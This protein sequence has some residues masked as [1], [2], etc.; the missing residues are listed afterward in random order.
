[1][2]KKTLAFQCIKALS[3]VAVIMLFY[4]AFIGGTEGSLLLPVA[5]AGGPYSGWVGETIVFDGSGSYDPTDTIIN[6]TWDFGDGYKEY[7]EIVTHSYSHSGDYIVT[8]SVLSNAYEMDTDS[9][10]AHIFEHNW[11]PVADAG[12]PYYGDVG[13]SIRFNGCSS[14]DSDGSIVTYHWHFGDGETEIGPIRYHTYQSSGI[15]LVTLTVYDDDSATDTDTSYAYIGGNQDPVADANGPY[16]GEVWEPI[17]FN[18]S[19]SSDPDGSIVSYTWNFGDGESGTGVTTTHAYEEAGTYTVTLIV[20]D[21]DGATDLDITSATIPG[22]NQPPSIPYRPSG[23]TTGS[24]WNQ[25]IYNTYST[26]PDGDKI[27]YLFDWGDGTTAY[28]ILYNSG[29]TAS[30][31]HSWGYQGA[32]VVRALAEDEH[33]AQSEWSDPLPIA[34]PLG[35]FSSIEEEQ[36]LYFLGR[37]LFALPI[38]IVIGPINIEPALRNINPIKQVDFAI[39]GD[40]KHTAYYEPYHWRISQS[41]N[42]LH[43]LEIAAYDK[44]GNAVI[45]SMDILFFSH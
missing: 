25:Y 34:M 37:K 44:E 5:D 7:G 39:D 6:Y 27:R 15:F 24:V 30:A 4:L 19:G 23:P 26:D 11:P 32:Y 29:D 38:T 40:V 3:V 41:L 20:T 8:L 31:Y 21:N 14:Y 16:S 35:V 45:K 17:T 33:G 12:G 43:V 42:G 22:D 10:Y 28:T 1:M 36:G 9:T 18:G 13:E 2:D